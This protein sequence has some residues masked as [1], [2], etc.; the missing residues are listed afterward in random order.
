MDRAVGFYRDVLGLS[1]GYTSPY[2][3]DFSLGDLKIGLHPPFDGS[4]APYAIRGK[5]WIIGV[6]VDDILS[7]RARLQNADVWVADEFHDIPGGV[8][9]DFEDPDGNAL[10]AMQSG[11]STKDLKE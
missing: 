6:G 1:A 9:L 3:S 10:Q 7:F 8:V 5:G 11:V 2:W 4:T